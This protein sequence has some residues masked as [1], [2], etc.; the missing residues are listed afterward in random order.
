MSST[1]LGGEPGSF[2]SL[3][4]ATLPQA[5]LHQEVCW[6]PPERNLIITLLGNKGPQARALCLQKTVKYNFRLMQLGK[7]T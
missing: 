4:R 5:A 1:D 3:P 6:K 2:D 7:T